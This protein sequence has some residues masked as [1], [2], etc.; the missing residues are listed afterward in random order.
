[1][2]LSLHHSI[3]LILQIFIPMRKKTKIA[4]KSIH[5][6]S[7]PLHLLNFVKILSLF[8]QSTSVWLI[9][10]SSNPTIMVVNSASVTSIGSQKLSSVLSSSIRVV[11]G[12]T[13]E[14]Q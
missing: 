13:P 9:R 4:V 3:T 1:M 10:S 8:S 5:P 11:I 7:Y 12:A 2:L 14:I 6:T